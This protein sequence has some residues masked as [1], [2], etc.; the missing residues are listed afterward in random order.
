MFTFYLGDAHSG[1]QLSIYSPVF[2]TSAAGY[3]L[4]LQLYPNGDGTAQGT[5][6]S[7]YIVIMRGEYD[8][9]LK[10]P[11]PYKFIFALLDQ[12]NNQRHII[13]TFTPDPNSTSFQQPRSDMNLAS[14]ITKFIPLKLLEKENNPYIHDDTMFIKVMVDFENISSDLFT[15]VCSANPALPSSLQYEL[16]REQYG[17]QRQ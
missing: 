11:F 13:E 8:A 16:I 2:Y 10:F 3:K 5:H 7:L 4:R 15:H 6:M 9:I 12:T 17:R 14:G 1:D